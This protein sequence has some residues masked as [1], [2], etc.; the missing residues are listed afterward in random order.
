MKSSVMFAKVSRKI[1]FLTAFIFIGMN[2]FSKNY[3]VQ[4]MKND[5]D[6]TSI[7]QFSVFS[8]PS[9]GKINLQINWEIRLPL[10]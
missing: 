6:V 1:I 4:N 7:R 5:S 2:A 3:F 10:R 9:K 8:N